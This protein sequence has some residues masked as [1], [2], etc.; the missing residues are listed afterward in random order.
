MTIAATLACSCARHPQLV[1]VISQKPNYEVEEVRLI[2]RPILSGENSLQVGGSKVFPYKR[3]LS[4]NL[5]TEILKQ[6]LDPKKSY[7][8]YVYTT[9]QTF[10][11]SPFLNRSEAHLSKI[12]DGGKMI[13]DASICE[14]HHCPMEFV[15]EDFITWQLRSKK[16]EHLMDQVYRHHALTTPGDCGVGYYDWTWRCPKCAAAVKAFKSKYPV[17]E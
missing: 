13:A 17:W 2:G 5:T 4:S 10:P 11:S 15:A 12:E 8:F 1:R 14:V 7:S 9:D 16:E 3:D 6:K